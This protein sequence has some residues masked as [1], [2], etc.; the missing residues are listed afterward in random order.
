VVKQK[1]PSKK[2]RKQHR[3][4]E[5]NPTNYLVPLGPVVNVA[6]T[7]L[8]D[9]DVDY[10]AYHSHLR[11]FL[12]R[13]DGTY[14]EDLTSEVARQEF[15]RF[16][17]EYNAGRLEQ[18]Y[19]KE[20]LPLEAL[21][22][23]KR[24]KHT[25]KFHTTSKEMESLHLVKEGVRKQTE[26]KADSSSAAAI[27][28]NDDAP[29]INVEVRST[30]DVCKPLNDLTTERRANRRL[31]EHVLVAEEELTGGKKDYGRER[32]LEI[33]QKRAAAGSDGRAR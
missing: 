5:V 3:H 8:L 26:Y 15:Q 20:V 25:W 13:D 28:V 21:N 19:Y 32:Q 12:F 11:L 16:V 22:Q 27:M 18:A 4:E 31:R 17:N 30:G 9:P 1:V 10:F 23:C 29:L 14:F 6:P 7:T 33:Q 24:T 2:K